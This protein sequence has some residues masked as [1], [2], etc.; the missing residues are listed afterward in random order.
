MKADKD[1]HTMT[2]DKSERQNTVKNKE[3]AGIK[4]SHVWDSQQIL[5]K[6]KTVAQNNSLQRYNESP[7]ANKKYPNNGNNFLKQQK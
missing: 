1:E 4:N 3:G 7:N 6:F 2:K 5:L